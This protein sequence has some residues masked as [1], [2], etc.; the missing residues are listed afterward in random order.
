MARG[1]QRVPVDGAG[2]ALRQPL[3][4]ALRDKLPAADLAA[5][6]TV[7]ASSPAATRDARQAVPAEGSIFARAGRIVVR[8][9][10]KGHGGKTATRIEGVVASARELEA[11]VREIKRALG[12][13]AMVDAGDIVVQGAQGERLVAFLEARGARKITVGS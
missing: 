10:R 9:E 6:D 11:A 1:K 3:L 8:R 12:C 5:P 13:G 4:A 7:A 2:E